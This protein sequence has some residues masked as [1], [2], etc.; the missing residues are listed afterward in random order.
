MLLMV[1][2]LLVSI[3]NS[4]CFSCALSYLLVNFDIV[5]AMANSA[6]SLL[7]IFVGE[8]LTLCAVFSDIAAAPPTLS[9]GDSFTL[10]SASSCF[11]QG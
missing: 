9:V 7:V 6:I 2:W 5:K 11:G 8:S 1:S 10:F 4:P 3:S